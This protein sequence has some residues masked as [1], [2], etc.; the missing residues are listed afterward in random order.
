MI[1]AI[2]FLCAAYLLGSIPTGV[3]VGRLRG[4]DI[5]RQGSG[6]VGATNVARVVG[7][8]P[9]FLVLTVDVAKGWIPVVVLAPMVARLSGSA[10][11]DQARILLGVAAV[12]GHIW[13]PFLQ[14]QGGKGVATALGV[15]WGLDFRVGL[16]ALAV[17]GLAAWWSRFVSIASVSAVVAAPFLMMF[18]GLPTFWIL[19]AIGVGLAIVARHRANF[20][21]LLHGE[22]HRIGEKKSE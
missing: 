18:L 22:E 6:N 21:R 16:G 1:L 3:W 7:K 14:F 13:N 8:L 17:W 2:P 20:L 11:A 10:S 15:L 5:R 12:A 4:V 19:G 9:G